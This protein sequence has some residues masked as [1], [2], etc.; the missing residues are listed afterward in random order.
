VTSGEIAK[1]L[2]QVL[3]PETK[4]IVG[5]LSV[6]FSVDSFAGGFV[7]QSIVSFWFFTK[8][9]VELTT[10][11]YI[12]SVAGVP[13]AFSFLASSKIAEEGTASQ[14]LRIY[15]EMSPRQYRHH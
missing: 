6:L 12:F 11:S 5:K 9:G 14:E 2:T 7:I 4:N 1:P 8:F 3:S 10:L 15:Q 13:T